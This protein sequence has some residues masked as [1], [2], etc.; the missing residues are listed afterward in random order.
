MAYDTLFISSTYELI[1]HEAIVSGHNV[2]ITELQLENAVTKDL[3]K[4]S[5]WQSDYYTYAKEIGNNHRD[6]AIRQYLTGCAHERHVKY[7][8][9]L[10]SDGQNQKCN[11]LIICGKNKYQVN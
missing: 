6:I 8:L 2:T 10:L 5:I 11:K 4:R 7:K 9:S 1:F 3:E